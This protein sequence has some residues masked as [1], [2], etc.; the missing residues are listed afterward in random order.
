MSLIYLYTQTIHIV[1]TDLK[2]NLPM[3]TP[4]DNVA[5]LSHC[6]EETHEVIL[7]LVSANLPI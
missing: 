5:Q 6:L 4:F 1:T 7:H 3:G 2:P